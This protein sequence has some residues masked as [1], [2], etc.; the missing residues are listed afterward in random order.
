VNPG[1]YDES[2]HRINYPYDS[3]VRLMVIQGPPGT[4]HRLVNVHA[5]VAMKEVTWRTRITNNNP[6]LPSP[7]PQSPN[8]TLISSDIMPTSPTRTVEAGVSY[9]I[10]GNYS[11]ALSVPLVPGVDSLPMGQTATD[12]IQPDTAQEVYTITPDWFNSNLLPAVQTPVLSASTPVSDID[13]SG[14]I[15][16]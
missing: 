10:E 8:E 14:I 13:R 5:P 11:F 12:P 2:I 9:M 6:S 4:P 16:P 7:V 15:A 1:S 3:G